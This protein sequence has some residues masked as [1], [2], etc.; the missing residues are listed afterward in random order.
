MTRIYTFLIALVFTS[1]ISAQVIYTIPAFPTQDEPITIIYD[2]TLGNAALMDVPP[3]IYA[4][5][6]VITTESA[7]P[8]DWKNVQGVWGTADPEV[9][10]TEIGDDLYQLSITSINDFLRA[11]C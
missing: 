4:H 11:N 7:S 6:G 8:T 3:P 5:T 9:L 2:A 1:G 10:M